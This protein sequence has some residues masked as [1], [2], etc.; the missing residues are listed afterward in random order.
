[1]HVRKLFQFYSFVALLTLKCENL[2]Y[3]GAEMGKNLSNFSEEERK[4]AMDRY[5][6]N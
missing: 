2:I 6:K 4:K 1:M 5:Y 3:E